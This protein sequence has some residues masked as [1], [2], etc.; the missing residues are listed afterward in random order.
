MCTYAQTNIIFLTNYLHIKLFNSTINTNFPFNFCPNYVFLKYLFQLLLCSFLSAQYLSSF[1]TFMNGLFYFIRLAL[2]L[3]MSIPKAPLLLI[4][5]GNYEMVF[6]LR[7]W[8][9]DFNIYRQ[10]L[11]EIISSKITVQWKIV[12]ARLAFTL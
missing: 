3:M 9:R 1:C 8:Q 6:V 12:V 2:Q 11:L 10:S 5:R 7:S 4:S